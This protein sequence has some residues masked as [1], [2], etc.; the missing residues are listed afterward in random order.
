MDSY[1]NDLFT[2]ILESERSI[3]SFLALVGKTISLPKGGLTVSR[4]IEEWTVDIVAAR[5]LELDATRSMQSMELGQSEL[6][7]SKPCLPFNI[8]LSPWND[9][10]AFSPLQERASKAKKAI[11]YL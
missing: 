1:H 5:A 4:S 2:Y 3:V 11:V 7:I 10:E 8:S 6:N 9:V